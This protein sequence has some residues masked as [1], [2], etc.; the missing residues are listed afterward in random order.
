M[1]TRADILKYAKSLIGFTNYKMG[2]K[3]YNYNNDVNKP[4]LLDCSGFVVWCYKMAGFKVADGTYM[5]W[6]TSEEVNYKDLKVGDIGIKEQ[7]GLGMYNHVG[8]YAGNGYWI[9]CNYSR[10][11]VTLEKTDIFK[12]YRRFNNIIFEDDKPSKSNSNKKKEDDEMIEKKE[13][14]VNNKKIKLD[15]IFKDNK[16]YVSLQSLKDANVL[17]ASYDK[18]KKIAVITSK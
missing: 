4:K 15:T 17:N 18:E 5:Q 3:H 9:H 2:A 13:F 6:Q 11:G 8:I 12:Y 16:N 14:I 1:K 10:N 7:G